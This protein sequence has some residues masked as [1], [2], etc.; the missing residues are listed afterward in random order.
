MLLNPTSNTD[1][2]AHAAET[3]FSSYFLPSLFLFC[4]QKDENQT[5]VANQVRQR[6]RLCFEKPYARP[7]CH[8]WHNTD[9][10]CNPPLQV[11]VQK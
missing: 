8:N 5:M 3:D 2:T 10:K 6:G 4:P 9:A 1:G 7:I 11:R